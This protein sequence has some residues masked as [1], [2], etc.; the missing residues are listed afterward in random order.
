MHPTTVAKI[1]AGDREIKLDEARRRL[2]SM[3][4]R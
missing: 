2:T 3:V 4:S 1:E